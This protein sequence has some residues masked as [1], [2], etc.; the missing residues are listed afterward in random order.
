MAESE[1]IIELDRVSKIFGDKAAVLDVSVRVPR[2]RCFAWLGPNGSGKTTL[3]RMMLGLAHPSTGTIKMRGFSMPDRQR[4]ALSRVGAVV[5]E[6]RFYRYLTGT[7]NLDVWAAL[8]GGDAPKRVASAIERVGMGPRAG[9]RVGTYSL[10]MR[11]RLGV[12]RCL[13]TDPELLVLD[14]PTNGLD[15]AGIVEFRQMI[16]RFVED[17][18]RTVFVSSH[19]LDEVQRMADNIAI[20]QAGRLVALLG[21]E[22]L[23]HMGPQRFIVRTDDPARAGKTLRGIRGVTEVSGRDAELI[24]TTES[25]DDAM[26]LALSAALHAAGLGII[27]LRAD[28][29]SLEERFLDI[30]S[31]AGVGDMAQAAP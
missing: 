29:Q 20:V 28:R 18:G 11:Q 10:G 24:V 15:P 13:L 26:A 25:T 5:E 19:L 23:L 9:D 16:R 6:P 22:H 14:E 2:G 31:T 17:E 1:Y 7:Q 12:A 27:E 4:E 3:I 8:Y 21:V 30:T